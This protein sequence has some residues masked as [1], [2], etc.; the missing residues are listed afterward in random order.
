MCGGYL[1]VVVEFAEIEEVARRSVV[2]RLHEFLRE[3]LLELL[4]RAVVD[5]AGFVG[6]VQGLNPVMSSVHYMMREM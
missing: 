4:Q 3:E 6:D 1:F 5:S 2:R